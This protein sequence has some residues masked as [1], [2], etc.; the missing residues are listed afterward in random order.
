[1]CGR[2]IWPARSCAHDFKE[3]FAVFF[4]RLAIADVAAVFILFV[5]VLWGLR[6]GSPAPSRVRHALLAGIVVV[7]IRLLSKVRLH[8]NKIG[9]AMI[10]AVSTRLL[11]PG[12]IGI[13]PES[14]HILS[15]RRSSR[16]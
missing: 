13:L 1:M 5:D 4:Q 9:I 2:H 8:R 16:L 7:G 11:R 15:G 14:T 12:A 6:S 10:S 3:L